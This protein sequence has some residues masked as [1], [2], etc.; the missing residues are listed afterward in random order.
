MRPSRESTPSETWTMKGPRNA[1]PTMTPFIWL[2]PGS[3]SRKNGA[4]G[5][6]NVQLVLARGM[7][8]MPER[9]T[10]DVEPVASSKPANIMPTHNHEDDHCEHVA[11]FELS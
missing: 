5:R 11:P 1:E 8:L 3:S 9:R 6:R 4:A 2:V 7:Q 10:N